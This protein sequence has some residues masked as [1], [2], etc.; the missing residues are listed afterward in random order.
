MVDPEDVD[1]PSKDR[2]DV[3]PVLGTIRVY[4]CDG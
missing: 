4:L 3:E 1:V 2:G